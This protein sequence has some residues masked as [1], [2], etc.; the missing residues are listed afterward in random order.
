MRPVDAGRDVVTAAAEVGHTGGHVLAKRVFEADL[1]SLGPIRD[2]V[3]KWAGEVG[4]GEE[5]RTDIR[6]DPHGRPRGCRM[7]LGVSV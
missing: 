4:L 5:P 6:H 3:G 2:F 7:G 1:E